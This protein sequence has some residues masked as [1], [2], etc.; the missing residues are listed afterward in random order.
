MVISLA[1]KQLVD[2]N[3]DNGGCNGGYFPAAFEYIINNGLTASMQY[4]YV[5]CR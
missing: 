2:C 4:P 5:S 1:E 3:S